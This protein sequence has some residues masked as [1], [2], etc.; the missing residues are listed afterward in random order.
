MKLSSFRTIELLAPAKNIE[1]GIAA[2]DHGADAVYIG[3][4]SFGAR[5]A[6]GNSVE[7]ITRLCQYAHQFNAKVYATV[8]TVIY[9]DELPLA[10]QLVR[11]LAAAGVDAILVQ[12]MGLL[13]LIA[14]A[15]LPSSVQLHA[16]TQTD[17]RTIEKVR[18]LHSLGFTRV[19]LARELAVDDIRAIHEAV[20]GVE[21]EVFVH[22]ALCVCYSGQCYAS[23]VCFGRSANR[24]ACAQMC[25]M[26]YALVD[27]DGHRVADDAYYL[28]LKDQC[29]LDNLEEIVRAGACS[30]KIE[31]RLKDVAYVKNVV[32]AY[33]QRLD[34][35]IANSRG[36]YR[37]ASWGRVEHSFTPDLK[38][39]FNRGYTDYF[40]HGRH[41]GIASFFTP[42]AIGEYVGKVKEI[43]Q[44]RMPSFNVAS[45]AAF[46][47]GD[48]LC[49]LDANGD[50]KGFRVNRAEGNRLF[51]LQMPSDLRPGTPLYRSQDQAFDK[52]MSGKTAVRTIP[53]RMILSDCDTQLQLTVEGIDAPLSGT[54]TLQLSER[55]QAQKPQADNLRR[56]LTKLGG[57]IYSYA[58]VVIDPSLNDLFVPS[59]TIADLR[60]R[61]VESI[62]PTVSPEE[63]D[64]PLLSSSE[65]VPVPNDAYHQE[66]T[67]LH[68]AVNEE[69]RRFYA[70]RGIV[71]NP[72][73]TGSLL[74]QCR[75]CI[76][77][78]LGYC[79]KNGGRRPDWKE[80]LSLR[81]G[82]G[83]LFPL[84][85]DCRNCQMNVKL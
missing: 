58:D 51:P 70:S 57:T 62:I 6:A 63:H 24:G 36:M 56:Q 33:S 34:A 20:P 27:A 84:H 18:W 78:S 13:Q 39:S 80:P 66:H 4:T 67:Y 8:N 26:K 14:D 44:G 28:S 25:R 69:S 52:L 53:L 72:D 61:A 23:E 3:A 35:I 43:R 59:S 22:G 21:L 37:R 41:E 49:Y 31:G 30:L 45:T 38:K 47:N 54:A 50:L 12:D 46:V 55:Q 40:L 82:D 48:G 32:A 76:R 75:H 29:Q 60:R 85:F 7:D 11:D 19:V 79:V 74:M 10:L 81:L 83:R 2:I 42:K 71:V 73:R 16:S 65:A 77:Y 64:A 17:N 1:C 68:N 15:H 9:D 5:H